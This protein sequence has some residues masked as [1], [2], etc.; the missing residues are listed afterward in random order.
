MHKDAVKTCKRNGN[1]VYT[2]ILG[3]CAHTLCNR[4]EAH[5]T[6]ETVDASLDIIALLKLIQLCMQQGQSRKYDMHATHDA[7]YQ[8]YHFYQGTNMSCHDYYGRYK[9]ITNTAILFG[10][11]MGATHSYIDAVLKTTVTDPKKPTE[12]EIEAAITTARDRFLGMGLILHSDPRR[13][14]GLIRDVKNQY[15]YGD[16]IYP[17]TLPKAY[18]IL[19]N[20]KAER[21][22]HGFENGGLNFLAQGLDPTSTGGR[23]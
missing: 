1:R 10:S 16:I 7:E 2:L 6:W 15:M 14:A 12:S 9:D 11:D 22:P 19:I 3:Q 8:F 13:Y 17:E 20:Y 5:P 23:G 21:P 18:D 4:V